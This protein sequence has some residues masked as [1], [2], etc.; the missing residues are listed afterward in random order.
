MQSNDWHTKPFGATRTCGT[1]TLTDLR[2]CTMGC[3][4]TSL[5]DSR[6]TCITM[7]VAIHCVKWWP[8]LVVAT[9]HTLSR[10]YM[11]GACD[12][13][14]DPESAY[15]IALHGPLLGGLNR[16]TS[17]HAVDCYYQA[18]TV[19]FN[20]LS[21]TVG[22]AAL[23][24]LQWVS[25][26]KMMT[27]PIHYSPHIKPWYMSGACESNDPERLL[28]RSPCLTT[29]TKWRHHAASDCS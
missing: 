21:W 4:T 23:H 7:G 19:F 12:V 13:A 17:S 26:C 1:Y 28:H 24:V 5:S 6:D 8:A 29:S 9:P 22:C 14:T 27:G 11:S 25:L 10:R 3:C 16:D 15:S 18:I 20:G 2:L